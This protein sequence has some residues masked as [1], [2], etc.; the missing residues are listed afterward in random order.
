MKT[1]TK[2]AMKIES[3]KR[4]PTDW[5]KQAMKESKGEWEHIPRTALINK[6]RQLFKENSH[7][8]HE[9]QRARGKMIRYGLKDKL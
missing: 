2:A 4:E 7:L 9:L 5:T 6:L 3:K 8:R 1:T